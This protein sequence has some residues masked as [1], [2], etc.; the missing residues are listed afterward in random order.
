MLTESQMQ[1]IIGKTIKDISNDK[2]CMIISFTDHS[3]ISVYH[4][5]RFESFLDWLWR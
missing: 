3:Y 1:S 4:K 2:Y 5:T